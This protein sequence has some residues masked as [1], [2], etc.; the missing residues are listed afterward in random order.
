MASVRGHMPPF[1]AQFRSMHGCD[2][3]WYNTCSVMIC[4][5]QTGSWPSA[6]MAAMQN[7]CDEK[8]QQSRPPWIVRPSLLRHMC[9]EATA[10]VQG[11]LHWQSCYIL[12]V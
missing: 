5:A 10:S 3:C 11:V 8:R 2:R 4:Q 12:Y 7:I 6:L 1:G 9:C